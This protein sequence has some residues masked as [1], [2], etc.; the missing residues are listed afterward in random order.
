[1]RKKAV[2]W[3][4]LLAVIH[5]GFVIFISYICLESCRGEPSWPLIWVLL[6][7]LDFPVSLFVGIFPYITLP[8]LPEP[9]SDPFFVVNLIWPTIFYGIFGTLWWFFLPAIFDS[10]LSIIKR[11]FNSK[12]A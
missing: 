10:M 8:F 7:F 1:M 5:F 6:L 9:F 2:L 12:G 11:W 4:I 3:G